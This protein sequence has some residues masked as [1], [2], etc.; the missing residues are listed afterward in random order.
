MAK[1]TLGSKIRSMV[2]TRLSFLL[3]FVIF[4]TSLCFVFQITFLNPDF[5]YDNMNS[6]HYFTDKKDELTQS[7]IDLGYASGLN[8]SFFENLVDEVMINE[9]T[10]NY[11]TSY[12]AGESTDIDDSS[13][14]QSF[15][16]ALDVFIEENSIENVNSA[17]RSYLVEQAALIYKNS[18]EIPLFT[19]IAPYIK[20]I[21][22]FMIPILLGLILFIGIIW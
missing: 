11:L 2:Y 1:K 17:S 20:A 15:N 19:T 7:L 22:T 5:I 14:K 8:E 3:S 18:L 13:F 6:S 4:F 10:L 12:Y 16:N 9:D 21:N